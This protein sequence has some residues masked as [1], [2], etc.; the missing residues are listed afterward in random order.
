MAE[1]SREKFRRSLSD[2]IALQHQDIQHPDF[3]SEQP[4][5]LHTLGNRFFGDS[6]D[7]LGSVDVSVHASIARRIFYLTLL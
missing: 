6:P 1:D 4:R 2:A 5:A 7:S 3:V